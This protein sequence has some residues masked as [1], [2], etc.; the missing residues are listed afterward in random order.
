MRAVYTERRSCVLLPKPL[1]TSRKPSTSQVRFLMQNIRHPSLRAKK[2]DE[3]RNIWQARRPEQI[4]PTLFCL[5]FLPARRS[6][7]ASLEKGGG[8]A[9]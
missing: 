3:A 8:P 5:T 6:M 9:K 7:K 2:Y 1:P 4:R